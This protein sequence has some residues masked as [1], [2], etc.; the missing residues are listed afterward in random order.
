MY[1]LYQEG[2]LRM[3]HVQTY[4]QSLKAA[5]VKRFLEDDCIDWFFLNKILKEASSLRYSVFIPFLYRFQSFLP[6]RGS[7]SLEY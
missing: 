3:P 7:V 1:N 4:C 5:W 6:L 2:G